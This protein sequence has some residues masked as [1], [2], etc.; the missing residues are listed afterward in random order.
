[1]LAEQQDNLPGRHIS[2]FAITRSLQVPTLPDEITQRRLTAHPGP[3]LLLVL[4][5]VLA[6]TSATQVPVG[7]RVLVDP[8]TS[9][10]EQVAEALQVITLPS[11][12]VPQV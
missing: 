1:L 9:G 2:Q 4:Q 5:V 11:A 8:A 6:A 3:T 12:I 10:R 7:V